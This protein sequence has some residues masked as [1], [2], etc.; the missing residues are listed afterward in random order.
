VER[1]T[2][3]YNNYEERLEEIWHTNILLVA[4][5]AKFLTCLGNVEKK[6]LNACSYATRC[7]PTAQ[8]QK[9]HTLQRQNTKEQKS[10]ESLRSNTLADA[11]RS[12]S[13]YRVSLGIYLKRPYTSDDLYIDLYAISRL[14]IDLI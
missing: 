9:R 3:K 4:R 12:R 1:Q 5:N 8:R 11:N 7:I 13:I 2:T 14:L 10:S 6:K